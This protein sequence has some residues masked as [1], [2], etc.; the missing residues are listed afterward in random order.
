[1]T[2][3]EATASDSEPLDP[4]LEHALEVSREERARTAALILEVL[5]GERTSGEV[6]AELG[7][8]LT[9]YY[10]LEERAVNGLVEACGPRRR[11]PRQDPEREILK[12]KG[13]VKRLE[14]QC[15]RTASLLRLSQRNLGVRP[16]VSTASESAKKNSKRSSKDAGGKKKRSRRAKARALTLAKKLR[17]ENPNSLDAKEKP[18]DNP[19]EVQA[20]K[21]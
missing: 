4:D 16:S 12:L 8:S 10:F 1:M 15:R 6:A 18:G 11:G 14:A 21:T 13:E 20:M 19:P 5:A 3:G 7:V 2:L 17:S 9:R